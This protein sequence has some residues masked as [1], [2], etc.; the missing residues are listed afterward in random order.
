MAGSD[1]ERHA[2]SIIMVQDD[3]EGLVG[4]RGNELQMPG[5]AFKREDFDTTS[6]GTTRHIL[7]IPSMG[8]SAGQVP[9]TT[10][11]RVSET[12]RGKPISRG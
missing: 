11:C 4:G 12:T 10:D 2:L 9:F 1:I 7:A 3:I 6:V 8:H 5:R